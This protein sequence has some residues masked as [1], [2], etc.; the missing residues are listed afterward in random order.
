MKFYKNVEYMYVLHPFLK[1]FKM[2]YY[3]FIFYWL[4]ACELVSQN[5]SLYKTH[6]YIAD[7]WLE[8]LYHVNVV[9]QGH[10]SSSSAP[11]YCANNTYK[12]L[13]AR[14]EGPGVR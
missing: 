6:V 2:I 5:A 10:L 14:I 3:F 8:I 9:H 1:V 4:G 11:D 12:W 7:Y 13:K